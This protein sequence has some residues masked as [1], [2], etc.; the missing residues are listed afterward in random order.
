MSALDGIRLNH[1]DFPAPFEATANLTVTAINASNF[2]FDTEG[3][4]IGAFNSLIGGGSTQEN[5]FVGRGGT[6]R[7]NV[8][9][10]QFPES[11]DSWGDAD[12]ATDGPIQLGNELTHQIATAGID[13]TRPATF[14]WGEFSSNGRYSPIKCVV[15]EVEV[16]NDVEQKPSSVQARID[17]QE[18]AQDTG[19][20]M[21]DPF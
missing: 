4:L 14:E 16:P 15:P 9:L 8:V 18:A 5:V 19:V 3:D 7:F 21:P 20:S 17:V 1:A 13:S 2:V 10:T 6:R 12:P 11:G